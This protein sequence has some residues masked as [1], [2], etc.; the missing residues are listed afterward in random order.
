MAAGRRGLWDAILRG[1]TQAAFD[2]YAR[3]RIYG[4]IMDELRTQDWM[5]KGSRR[6]VAK[7][8]G[9]PTIVWIEDLKGS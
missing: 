3:I 2:G 6:R 8:E 9:V 7:E 4:A 5:P 1:K